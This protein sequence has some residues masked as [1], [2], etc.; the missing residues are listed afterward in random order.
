MITTDPYANRCVIRLNQQRV[1]AA[2]ALLL[3]FPG[4]AW[5]GGVVTT[6]TDAALRAAFA[7][8][9][10]I[11][12]ACDGTITLSNTMT[13]TADT[14][15]DGGGRNVTISGGGGVQVFWV[16]TNVNFTMHSLAV[17]NGL[18]TNGGGVYNAGGTLNA[19]NCTFSDNS[20]SGSGSGGPGTLPGGSGCG[21][22]IYNLG[23][24]NASQCAFLRN[25][26]VGGAG[27]AGWGTFGVGIAGSSGGA[28]FGGAIYNAGWA[29]MDCSLFATN[30]AIGGS[31]GMGG[32]NG[33]V[34]G[35]DENLTGGRGGDGGCGE[36]G[37]LFNVSTAIVVNCT[38][39]SNRVQGGQGGLGG[40]GGAF[41]WNPRGPIAQGFPGGD[42]GSG[43]PG[44]ETI[45]QSG[46]FLYLGNCTVAC[47]SSFGGNAGPGGAGWGG[48]PQRAVWPEWPGSACRGWG[49]SQPGQ[50]PVGGQLSRE[51]WL[52]W[53][54]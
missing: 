19:T 33:L 54:H 9:G 43:G 41:M 37:A 38:F 50:H 7:G 11:T 34:V 40:M 45:C 25:Q 10:T 12:F 44:G 23:T 35:I 2:F 6:C 52:G 49:N 13:I 15:L 27:S 29:V 4:S 47:N 3:L 17:A 42:G 21:G 32:N 48:Y 24:F 51:Q 36:G 53:A 22:A 8:G 28:G 20:A 46:G 18:S 5:A 31:G 14:V 16:S 30:V 39:A 1:S 26:A